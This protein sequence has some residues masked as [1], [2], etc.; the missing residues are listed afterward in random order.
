MVPIVYYKYG[1]KYNLKQKKTPNSAVNCI[2]NSSKWSLQYNIK[3]YYSH[4]SL[5]RPLSLELRNEQQFGR[6][7]I[8][9]GFVIKKFFFYIA[10]L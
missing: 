2:L 7:Y 8:E 6:K 1:Y 9:C 4:E 5:W 3:R 10:V